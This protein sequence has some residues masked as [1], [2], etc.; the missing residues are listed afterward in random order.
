MH[1]TIMQGAET[2]VCC[3]RATDDTTTTIVSALAL[4][5]SASS[6]TARRLHSVASSAFSE[7]PARQRRLQASLTTDSVASLATSSNAS[8]MTVYEVAASSPTSFAVTSAALTFG[9][10]QMLLAG[11]TA[12]DN[13]ILA[14]AAVA[15]CGNGVCELGERPNATAAGVNATG[16]HM[17]HASARN[18]HI[19]YSIASSVSIQV[20][21]ERKRP[22]S[23]WAILS[24]FLSV[25]DSTLRGLCMI[26]NSQCYCKLPML[27]LHNQTFSMQNVALQI[28]MYSALCAIP[29]YPLHMYG[30]FSQPVNA[31]LT[32]ISAFLSP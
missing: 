19:Q 1:C 24:G 30:S 16:V 27:I 28:A 2:S 12:L 7:L 18:K 20:R 10:A 3:C 6:A 23:H 5:T 17:L 25:F 15:V 11:S 9:Q 32:L 4:E 8:S 13:E 31:C 22:M 14:I 29:S 26:S 21:T